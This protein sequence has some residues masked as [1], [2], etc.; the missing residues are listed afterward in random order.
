VDFL[1]PFG[2]VITSL[3]GGN[4]GALNSSSFKTVTTWL[5]GVSGADDLHRHTSA[6]VA[7]IQATHGA[8][9]GLDL[10][11][12]SSDLAQQASAM[13]ASI[14]A[15]PGA[16]DIRVELDAAAAGLAVDVFLAP[17]AA[18]Q[19]RYASELADAATLAATLVDTGIS[20]A[21]ATAAAL[22]TALAP[23]SILREFRDRLL[24]QAGL[25]IGQDGVAGLLRGILA[26]ITPARINAI[27]DPII[28]AV[29]GRAMT[30]LNA[31]ITPVKDAITHFT[32][33]IDAIDLTP[34]R[35]SIDAIFNQM[36]AQIEAL[37]P[38]KI[39]GPTLDAFDRLK[40]DLM[41]FDP[42][43]DLRDLI[44]ALTGTATRVLGKLKAEELLASPIAIFDELGKALSAID[45]KALLQPVLDELDNLAA[46]VASGLDEIAQAIERL[47]AALPAPG[48]GGVGG[49]IS[50]AVSVS[51]SLG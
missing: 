49:A 28:A 48:G 26:T 4:G 12:L 41:A 18:N 32:A 14:S 23:A 51:V 2:D 31:V 30:L 10:Q 44:S 20:Q 11:S 37:D 13:R 47:Q 40:A 8:V 43:K 33:A 35:Q 5:T 15:L 3:L 38:M 1:A 45:P 22:A 17:L 29:H 46:Q 21:D 34:L 27:L 25:S 9:Q 42:L 7:A 6:V 19:A 36:L 50:A 24:Q 16:L 39:L